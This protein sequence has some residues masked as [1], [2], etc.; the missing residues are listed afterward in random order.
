MRWVVTHFADVA[1]RLS[2]LSQTAPPGPWR[3][4]APVPSSLPAEPGPQP[5]H[6]GILSPDTADMFSNILASS[7][8]MSVALPQCDY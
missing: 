5:Q 4:W 6:Q 3:S 8:E 2:I 7:H 1:Q